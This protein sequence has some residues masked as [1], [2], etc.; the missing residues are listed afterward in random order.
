MAPRRSTGAAKK[1]AAKGKGAAKSKAE[2]TAEPEEVQT[3]DFAM[4]TGRDAFK[5]AVECLK[6]KKLFPAKAEKVGSHPVL[7]NGW[8]GS[9]L[10]EA[11]WL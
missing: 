11:P 5:D 6:K 1:A 4:E 2:A 7:P 9:S 3:E 8:Q 10:K